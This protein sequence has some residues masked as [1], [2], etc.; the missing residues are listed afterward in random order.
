[1]SLI[2]N[3]LRATSK[4]TNSQVLAPPSDPL[5]DTILFSTSITVIQ[6]LKAG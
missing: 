1:M 3:D 2:S 5:D 4:S 6:L